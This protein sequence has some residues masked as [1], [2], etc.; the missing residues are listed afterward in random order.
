M[1]EVA[2]VRISLDWGLPV[3]GKPVKRA[4]SRAL[5]VKPADIGRVDLLKRSIDARKKNDVHF[6]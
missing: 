1:I 3:C 2:N 6:V 5:G 4:L